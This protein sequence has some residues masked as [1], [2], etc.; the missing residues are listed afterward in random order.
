MSPIPLAPFG[1]TGHTSTRIIFGAAAVGSVSQAVADETLDLL[2]EHGVNHIDTAASYG[3]SEIRMGPWMAQHRQRFFLATKTAERTY[4]AA[5]DEIRRS[6]ER[7][8]VDSVDLLQIHNL[9]EDAEWQVAMGDDGAL[10][11]AIEAREEGLT[12]FIGVTGHGVGA[13]AMHKRSLK[14]YDFDSVLLPYNYI[15]AQNPAYMRD[16]EEL[17]TL[18]QERDVAVQTIK[19]LTRRPW[20]EGQ[21][22]H[23]HT[24]YEPFVEQADI[25]LAVH[26]VLARPGIFLNTSSDVSLLRKILDAVSRSR[27]CPSDAEMASLMERQAVEPLFT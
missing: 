2:L 11:A 20:A 15:M 26:W 27:A 6:L 18:C 10:N 16:F 22:R 7:L 17:T 8:R 21:E 23:I 13:P 9:I 5:H 3:N 24:W 25:D 19:S 14:R 1:R 12:R 4:Q